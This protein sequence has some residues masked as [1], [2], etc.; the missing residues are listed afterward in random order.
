MVIY[1][2]HGTSKHITRK[3]YMPPYFSSKL[4]EYLINAIFT[5]VK[6]QYIENTHTHIF[7]YIY[8]YRDMSN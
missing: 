8:I 4:F 7:M 5:H 3:P 1:G 2:P 6:I